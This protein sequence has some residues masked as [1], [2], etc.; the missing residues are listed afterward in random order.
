MVHLA[1]DVF[2]SVG[3]NLS[4]KAVRYCKDQIWYSPHRIRNFQLR[5]KNGLVLEYKISNIFEGCFKHT[6]YCILTVYFFAFNSTTTSFFNLVWVTKTI[7]EFSANWVKD[8]WT[9]SANIILIYIQI[10][11]KLHFTP[12]VTSSSA[13]PSVSGSGKGKGP[14]V[15]TSGSSYL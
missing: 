12:P 14:E 15:M 7:F 10:L 8:S 6:V 5:P 11:I 3:W 9:I 2:F 1:I 13:P 4:D